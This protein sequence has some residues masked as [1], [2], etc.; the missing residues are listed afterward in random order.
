MSQKAN[1][2]KEYYEYKIKSGDTLSMIIFRMFGFAPTDSRYKKTQQY[3][4]EL[5]P[6]VKDI[7]KI[8]AG[9]VLRLGV[10]P[11]VISP[12]KQVAR[13][14]LSSPIRLPLQ[15]NYVVHRVAP[16]D[17]DDFWMLSWLANNSNYLTI[18]GGVA[19]GATVN[20]ASP[21]NIAL[22][23]QINDYYADYKSGKITKGQYD[24]L[25]KISLD[26]LKTNIG[27]FEKWLFGPQTTHQA[28]RIARGG[29]VPAGANIARHAD[30]LNKLAT[31]GKVGGYALVGVGLT[32]SCMQI[33]N[34]QNKQEKNEI[35]V[36]TVA[37]TSI[38]LVGGAL[39][40]L[41]LVSNPIG[42]GTALVLATGSAAISY[43]SGKF[44]KKLYDIYGNEV[45]FVEGTGVNKLCR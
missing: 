2:A 27:P 8:K 37:S 45:D 40:G 18:P 33:A 31:V 14:E 35:F 38:G 23:T 26:K 12:A 41:F 9:D 17:A 4:L 39:L 43:G 15:E 5:N 29:G 7:N 28:I 1:D 11:P 34:T 42:W 19:T 3:L 36:E 6:Q 44:A 16:K 21:A 22:M 24:R 20:F 10:L 32:A 13:R 25:R 30:R